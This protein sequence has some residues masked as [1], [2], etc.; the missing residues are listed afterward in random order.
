M[1]D[2][3]TPFSPANTIKFLSEKFNVKSSNALKSAPPYK[4]NGF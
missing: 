2:L 4:Q 1:D 3:P